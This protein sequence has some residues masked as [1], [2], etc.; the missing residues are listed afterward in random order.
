LLGLDRKI[1]MF[2]NEVGRLNAKLD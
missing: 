2:V 1:E